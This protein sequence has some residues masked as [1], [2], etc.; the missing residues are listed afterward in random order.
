MMKKIFSIFLIVLAFSAFTM[1]SSEVGVSFVINGHKNTTT[2][3]VPST[4]FWSNYGCYA[5]AIL[6][7][8][9]LYY[10]ILKAKNN[11]GRRPKKKN[12]VKKK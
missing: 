8:L 9:V 1:A 3:Y 11:E 2:N 6:V 4:S 10:I 7:I 5:V 12:K